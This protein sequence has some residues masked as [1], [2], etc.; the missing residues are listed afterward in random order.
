MEVLGDL[1]RLDPSGQLP[2]PWSIRAH[3]G[4]ESNTG[5]S[6]FLTQPEKGAV[7]WPTG[8]MRKRASHLDAI[9]RIPDILVTPLTSHKL[10]QTFS[11][12]ISVPESQGAVREVL[13]SLNGT[14]ANVVL[15]DTLTREGREDHTI[16]LVMEPAVKM[17]PET[18][19]NHLA[20]VLKRWKVKRDDIRPVFDAA[21]LLPQ[22]PLRV[23]NGILPPF[24]WRELITRDYRDR[25][26]SYDLRKVVVSSNPDR[27][28]LR[29]I[30]PIRGVVQLDIPHNNVPGALEAIT[31]AI[32]SAGYNILSSRLSRTP[33]FPMNDQMSVFVAVCEPVSPAAEADNAEDAAR[34]RAEVKRIVLEADKNFIAVPRKL[35]S[36]GRKSSDTRYS[37]PRGAQI[38]LPPESLLRK[39]Q[40]EK[41]LAEELYRTEFDE[42]RL[43]AKHRLNDA[44]NAPHKVG[45]KAAEQ[46]E[47][48]KRA[49]A[50]IDARRAKYGANPRK[51]IFLSHR[52]VEHRENAVPEIVRE[53]TQSIEIIRKAIKDAGCFAFTLPAPWDREMTA[54]AIFPSLWAANACLVLALDEKGSGAP[55]LS[56]A[57]EY[58]FFMGQRKKAFM[59]VAQS[60]LDQT[61]AL[62]NL[63]GFVRLTYGGK[64]IEAGDPTTKVSADFVALDVGD[65]HPPFS[66]YNQ[67]I[68]CVDAL[69]EDPDEAPDQRRPEDDGHSSERGA[70]KKARTKSSAGAAPKKA[71]S[72]RPR[73]APTKAA[74]TTKRRTV[75]KARK[76]TRR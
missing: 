2:L 63:D 57:H 73:K 44:L 61:H 46:I 55:S 64:R 62:G 18:F 50:D 9:G 16:N 72:R 35:N 67:V 36:F 26:D 58:G 54:D 53:H 40:E 65:P 14:D 7:K 31:G 38:V 74:K 49:L 12:E 66:L 48:C 6:I 32:N 29:Y 19:H 34:L 41:K 60:R 15:S 21:D 10:K 22:P 69:C 1:I 30:F 43:V 75:A 17:K 37:L 71:T 51:L 56:Q 28:I 20:R 4:L 27:R 42:D 25:V 23:Q 70:A 76:R 45:K 59:L 11:V 3:L 52:F 33:R 47:S 68:K 24:S 13:A 39:I 5:V 8:R